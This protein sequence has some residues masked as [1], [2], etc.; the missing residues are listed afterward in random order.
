[1]TSK[2]HAVII[3]THT[4]LIEIFHMLYMYMLIFTFV[5]WLKLL[6]NYNPIRGKY[7]GCNDMIT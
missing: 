3:Y 7:K 1:M 6:F 4:V 2:I 5:M